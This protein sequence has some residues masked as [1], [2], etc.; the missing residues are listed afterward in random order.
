MQQSILDR[1]TK[2][3]GVPGLPEILSSQLSGADLNSLLLEVFRQ[4]TAKMQA[5]ELMQTYRQNRFVQPSSVDA[6]DFQEFMLTAL[7]QSTHSGFR[8][9]QLSPLSPLGT[10]SVVATA[11]QDKIVSA[12]RGTEVVADATNVLALESVLRRSKQR[13]PRGILHFS[14]THRHVRAQEIP[15]I[16]GYSAHFAILGL[17]SAGRDTGSFLFEKEC[18]LRHIRFYVTY[19]KNTLHLPWIKIHLKSL[20]QEGVPNRLF[21]SVAAHIRQCAPD[22]SITC[23]SSS[24]AEQAYYQHVQFKIVIPGPEGHDIEIADGGF[25]DW[26]QRLS[27]SRKERFLIS[28]LGVELL[29]K[30]VSREL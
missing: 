14:T 24:A 3:S 2:K 12:L 18:L 7:R 19:L 10:C 5:P 8:P 6:I 29:Y 30:C 15:D 20:N 16:P 21:D 9:L 22:W 17:T 4:K 13:F 1:I 27:G 25:T 28:G 11:H 23:L 26:T